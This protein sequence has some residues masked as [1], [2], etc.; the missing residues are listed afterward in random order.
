M[1]TFDDLTLG[2]V[3]LIQTV[4]LGGKSMSHADSDPMMVAGGV[5]WII[6]RKDNPELSWDDFKASVS[7]GEIK[8]MSMEA[9][10]HK[11]DPPIP[12]PNLS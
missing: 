10:A 5:L 2:E 9:E 12:M 7:M 11:L 3:E 8:A 4:A 1:S 6:R